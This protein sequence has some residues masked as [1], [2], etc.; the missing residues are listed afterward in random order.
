MIDDLEVNLT[1]P[2]ERGMTTAWV[3]DEP[4]ADG[5]PYRRI[6]PRQWQVRDLPA[7]LGDLT[8]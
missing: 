6:G 8:T 3:A 2:H 1:L 4:F 7:Y 5:T